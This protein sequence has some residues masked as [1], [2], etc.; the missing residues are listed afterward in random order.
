MSQLATAGKNGREL[1]GATREVTFAHVRSILNA[2]VADELIAKNPATGVGVTK[3]KAAPHIIT[4]WSDEWLND[5]V[6]ELPEQYRALVTMG[7]GLGLRQGE[8][9][10]LDPQD[11]DFLRSTV[12]VQRQIKIVGGRMVY[13]RPKGRDGGKIRR[14]PVAEDIRDD[15]A[16]ALAAFPAVDVTL[17]WEVPN[18]APQTARLIV[19]TPNGEACNR[20]AFN[21]NVWSPA[22]RR[23]GIPASRENGFHM[24][25]HLFATTLL[26]SGINVK[27]VSEWLGHASPAFT[28]Q[29]Y[30]GFM[31]SN[32]G[33][34]REAINSRWRAPL[35]P[36]GGGKPALT[37]T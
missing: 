16:A 15:L 7:F 10:A 25:R 29:V 19:T 33:R 18:G 28:I 34:M 22:R 17:P 20:N 30:G 36:Q 8:A 13:S 1:S 21:G 11:I 3:P 37:S 12:T 14:L 24:L 9:F 35:V 31:P 4:P 32:E 5:M 6:T 27:A 26:E 2:A 23:V